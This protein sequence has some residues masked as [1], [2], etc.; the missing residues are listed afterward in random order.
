MR[1]KPGLFTK[2][3]HAF[4]IGRPEEAKAASRGR[5]TFV[6]K[7]TTGAALQQ[8]ATTSPSFHV[9]R[10]SSDESSTCH[11][12]SCLS[13]ASL[14]SAPAGAGGWFWWNASHQSN[15]GP[16]AMPVLAVET[17]GKGA[18]TVTSSPSGIDCGGSWGELCRW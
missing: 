1:P 6:A 4:C 12:R 5:L 14:S 11:S 3:A 7:S 15:G 10:G 13:P 8:R 17:T 18:G 16:S 9:R 2:S